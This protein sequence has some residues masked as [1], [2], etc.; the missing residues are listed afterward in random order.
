MANSIPEQL[1][2]IVLTVLATTSAGSNVWRSRE[3]ALSETDLP[4]I[5]LRRVATQQNAL[6]MES[7][8]ISLDFTLEIFALTE[9]NT[10]VLHVEAH[11][12]LNASAPLAQTL[13]C[14]GTESDGDGADRSYFRLTAHYQLI[15]WV[16]HVDISQS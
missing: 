6:T 2:A 8:Q 16:S 5:N 4:G 1:L 7:D 11:R 15:A 9:L 10:D 12:V 3:D 14:L 13:N